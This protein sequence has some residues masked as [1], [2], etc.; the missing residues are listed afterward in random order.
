MKF[1]VISTSNMF[2]NHLTVITSDIP[3]S[4]SIISDIWWYEGYTP[5][6][7]IDYGGGG[8][9]P[10]PFIPGGGWTM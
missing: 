2:D 8:D 6:E 3:I 7:P 10:P 5:I 4:S 9:D 1:R